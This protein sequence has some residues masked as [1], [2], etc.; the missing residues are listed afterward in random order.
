MNRAQE[1][2]PPASNFAKHTCLVFLSCLLPLACGDPD[3]PGISGTWLGEDDDNG[4][5][6]L[7]LSGSAS[8]SGTYALT[9]GL[10]TAALRGDVSGQ[11]AY[12]D[13]SLDFEIMWFADRTQ[14]CE[15]RGRMAESGETMA[16]GVTCVGDGQ[17]W[18]VTLDLRRG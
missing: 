15:F 17:E 6:E 16:G 4:S 9:H 8:L 18:R 13:I 7:E 11:Y 10:E 1:Y 2:P 14:T 5:W 3:T 12:P